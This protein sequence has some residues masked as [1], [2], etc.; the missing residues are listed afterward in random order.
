MYLSKPCAKPV[1]SISHPLR[2][3]G[4][5]LLELMVSQAVVLVL[6]GS[7]FALIVAQTRNFHRMEG[8]IEAQV[9]L[10]QITYALMRDLQ[11]IGGAD[12]RAG[13][14]LEVTDNTNGPDQLLVFKSNPALC[15]S[16]LTTVAGAN[17]SGNLL[18]IAKTGSTCPIGNTAASNAACH[19]DLVINK[20]ILLASN[21]AS[22][23]LFATAVDTSGCTIT[24][25]SSNALNTA[26]VTRLKRSF[27]TN[28][29]NNLTDAFT[30]IFAG[31]TQTGSV[32]LGSTLQYR[33]AD[34]TLLRS[35]DR[36]TEE[37]LLDNIADLQIARAYDT[38]ND[39]IIGDNEWLGRTASLRNESD[40]T[41]ASPV[42]YFGAEVIL[43][44]SGSQAYGDDHVE[45]D[46]IDTAFNHSL[47]EL[48]NTGR[49][50]RWSRVFMAARNRRN[51]D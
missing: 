8:S 22:M 49:T 18:K 46:I 36:Q 27:P 31:N 40:L 32:R 38:N 47:A 12:G 28:T 50:Y 41:G 7:I 43:V 33:V 23:R 14:L 45:K 25:D 6:V 30:L 51:E 5:T 11:A 16:G 20:D 39:G 15:N 35:V 44:A 48:Q 24:I 34:N 9:S 13:E 1:F 29:V 3:R 42:T 37:A 26:A 10:R 4:M 19:K 17:F 21:T 2:V